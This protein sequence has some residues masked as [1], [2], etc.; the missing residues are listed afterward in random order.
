MWYICKWQGFVPSFLAHNTKH[1]FTKINNF[2][3]TWPALKSGDFIDLEWT[4]S[5]LSKL[6]MTSKWP[7]GSNFVLLFT[8]SSLEPSMIFLSWLSMLPNRN[9]KFIL[10][11]LSDYKKSH[12]YKIVVTFIS[13]YFFPVVLQYLSCLKTINHY[14]T[15]GNHCIYL[16]II[17]IIY[18]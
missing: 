4:A 16:S 13:S 18:I 5:Y 10:H 2:E 8:L 1:I 12:T 9:T 11:P 14:Q 15:K 17:F 6:F 7:Q 3:N